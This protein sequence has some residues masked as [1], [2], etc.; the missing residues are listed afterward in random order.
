MYS[1]KPAASIV[2]NELVAEHG[3]AKPEGRRQLNAAGKEAVE[4]TA[5]RLAAL[6][7]QVL[8]KHDQLSH[9]AKG[10]SHCSAATGRY[11]RLL[12]RLGHPRH[13]SSTSTARR[14][15]WWRCR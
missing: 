12:V 9:A 2:V 11:R 3:L 10:R 8:G 4:L 1:G 15:R 7:D 6:V 13:R 5:E 14:W